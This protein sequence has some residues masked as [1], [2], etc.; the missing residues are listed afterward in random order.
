[1]AI[2][3]VPV[4]ALD[5]APATLRDYEGSVLLVVNVASK[6][7]LTPQYAGLERVH[8]KFAERGFS[9]LG[10]PCNQFGEQEPGSASEIQTFC[11]TSYG[12]TFPMFEKTDVNGEDQHPLYTSLTALADDSGHSG[13]IRWNFEKF[14]VNRRGEPVHR[15]SPLVEPES[16]E[17]LATIEQ[18]LAE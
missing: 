7:G 18:L 16:A 4:R 3:D 6:C 17:L 14:L 11:S 13:E 9:V 15:F 5:G 2:Y 12:V 1:M 10:F 8:E